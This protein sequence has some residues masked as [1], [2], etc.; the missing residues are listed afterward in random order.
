MNKKAIL[1]VFALAAFFAARS[2]EAA[3]DPMIK[4]GSTINMVLRDYTK[5]EKPKFPKRASAEEKIK[6]VD[7]F[8]KDALSGANQNAG[9]TPITFKITNDIITPTQSYYETE[10]SMTPGGTS[11]VGT[12]VY[13]G[14]IGVTKDSMMLLLQNG[15]WESVYNGA[16]V[17]V[18]NF[19]PV[20]FPRQPKIGTVVPQ[21]V[22]NYYM[23]VPKETSYTVMRQA[24]SNVTYGWQYTGNSGYVGGVGVAGISRVPLSYT[25]STIEAEVRS[26]LSIGNLR[27]THMDAQ[28][29]DVRD[30]Q[31]QGKTYKAY[32]ITGFDYMKFGM[33]IDVQSAD[34]AIEKQARRVSERTVNKIQRKTYDYLDDAGY[35]ANEEG[36]L[37]IPTEEW[38]VPELGIV[39]SIAYD[40]N[41]FCQYVQDYVGIQ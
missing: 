19:S 27:L 9:V 17:G 30:Y 36:F 31:F 15:P 35:T 33:N 12:V 22:F 1:L 11:S 24:I 7:A 29:T 3:L 40:K 6:I 39:R 14:V 32:I 41:G 21:S 20:F 16:V 4:K 34:K 25:I 8:N 23:S 28:I 2:Q 26:K 37:V 38:L 13:K 5:L 10:Y 18:M